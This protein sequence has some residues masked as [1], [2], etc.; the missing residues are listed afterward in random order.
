LRN[1]KSVLGGSG[2][3]PW[4][5]IGYAQLKKKSPAVGR[6]VQ[7]SVRTLKLPASWPR[8]LLPAT[9]SVLKDSVGQDVSIAKN[10]SRASQSFLFARL[11]QA[12]HDLKSAE[13]WCSAG[14]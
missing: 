14:R 8:K 2:R 6:L 1:S 7:V 12:T 11:A 3:S 5:K 10:Y 13:R 9:S 4:P